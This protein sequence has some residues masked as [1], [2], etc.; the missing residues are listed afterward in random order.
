ME[1][2]GKFPRGFFLNNVFTM[3]F[4]GVEKVYGEYSDYLAIRLS[5]EKS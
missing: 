4:I 5:Y 1:P 3:S 2:L